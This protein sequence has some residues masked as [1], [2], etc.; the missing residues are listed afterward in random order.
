MRLEPVR[1][2]HN[3]RVPVALAQLLSIATR[4]VLS[5]LVF[6]DDRLITNDVVIDNHPWSIV[7]VGFGAVNGLNLVWLAEPPVNHLPFPLL[8]DN[9]RHQNN[10]VLTTG[11]LHGFDSHDCFARTRFISKQSMRPPKW[12]RQQMLNAFLL[13]V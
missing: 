1:L 4:D 9:R 11:F 12:V 6:L 8:F 7:D 5:L 10:T 13:V 3:Q 2:I